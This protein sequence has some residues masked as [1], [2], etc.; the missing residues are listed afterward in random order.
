MLHTTG[1]QLEGKD[2][3]GGGWGSEGNSAVGWLVGK[4]EDC[5]QEAHFTPAL[6]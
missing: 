5:L 3:Q 2:G 6:D 4:Q 1:T